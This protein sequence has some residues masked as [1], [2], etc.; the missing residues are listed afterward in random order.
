MV[1]AL[2]AQAAHAVSSFSI[3]TG[4]L[5]NG[6]EGAYYSERLTASISGVTWSIASGALPDGLTLNPSTGQITGTPASR[7]AGQ[8]ELII[9]ARASGYSA[10]AKSFRFEIKA[11]VIPVEITKG[12]LNN[13]RVNEPYADAVT[14]S[15]SGITWSHTGS[16][17]GLT[18]DDSTGVITGTPTTAGDYTI[19]VNAT[20]GQTSDS[21]T[22]NVTI[23]PA[24]VEPIEI[25]TNILASGLTGTPYQVELLS[26]K[27]SATWSI[28]SGRLPTGLNLNS[29]TGII[30]GT[31]TT[32]GLYTFVVRA[33]DGQTETY[34]EFDL[35]INSANIFAISTTGLPDGTVGTRYTYILAA[36]QTATWELL[37]GQLPDGLS[38]DAYGTI[39]GTPTTEETSGFQVRATANDGSTDTAYFTLR[40]NAASAPSTNE[41]R[42]TTEFLEDWTANTPHEQQIQA[43]PAGNYRWRLTN[44]TLPSGIQFSQSGLLSGTAT[45]SGTSTIEITVSNGSQT[46]SQFFT[47]RV[48]PVG[49]DFQITTTSTL[50][51][52]ADKLY[53]FFFRTNASGPVSWVANGSLPPGLQLNPSTGELSG[54]PTV[55]GQSLVD[56]TASS[57][58]QTASAT[59]TMIVTGEG[60]GGDD[61]DSSGCNTGAGIYALSLL[62]S[63]FL[64]RRRH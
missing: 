47:L 36:T 21:K 10:T 53:S 45:Q 16:I 1:L 8:Y 14:A 50:R 38:L 5:A 25:L 19:T 11:Q 40:I 17:P 52:P 15:T 20:N 18:F 43:S 28:E 63:F 59:I 24:A 23:Y 55:P 6:S 27:S 54:I 13:G 42:I 41:L 37:S 9:S 22:Y 46:A 7:S 48:V 2:A 58:G 32:T 60:Y 30:S 3:I 51:I 39:S 4:S 44:G 62:G 29:S 56:I 64:L 49:G 57:G 35:T 26:N 34:K 61:D 33:T 31:P 12:Y